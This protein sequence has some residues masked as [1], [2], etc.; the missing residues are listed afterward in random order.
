MET[1]EDIAYFSGRILLWEK[2]TWKLEDLR[3]MHGLFRH[4]CEAARSSSC[5][6]LAWL[7]GPDMSLCRGLK[8]DRTGKKQVGEEATPRPRFFV[9]RACLFIDGN[10]LRN[11]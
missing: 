6:L 2:W 8:I 1:M 11:T 9:N 10:Y 5:K 4:F 3:Q 7:V